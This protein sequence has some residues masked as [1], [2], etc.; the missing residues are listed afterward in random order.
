MQGATSSESRASASTPPLGAQPASPPHSL[1]LTSPCHSSCATTHRSSS[2]L[3]PPLAPLLLSAQL[4]PHSSSP[5]LFLFP[6]SALSFFF[7]M[8]RRPPSSTLFPYTTL[9]RSVA[10][11][12]SNA[13]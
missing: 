13:E 11:H 12:S 7:L 1:A 8:I 10:L 9:F 4:V 2:P 3:S 5:R 6:L